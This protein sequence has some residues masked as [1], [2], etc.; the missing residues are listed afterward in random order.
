MKKILFGACALASLLVA[1]VALTSCNNEG[2]TP[3]QPSKEKC[4]KLSFN[5]TIS[6][7]DA[8]T[9]ALGYDSENPKQLNAWWE[10]TEKVYAVNMSAVMSGGSGDVTIDG[11]LQPS[12]NG[13]TT[14]LSGWLTPAEEIHAMEGKTPGDIL[15]FVYPSLAVDYTGQDGTL[16]TIA[17]KYDYAQA[18]TMVTSTENGI[19]EVMDAS[20]MFL[21]GKDPEPDPKPLMAPATRGSLDNTIPFISSQAIVKFTLVDKETG[22]PINATSLTIDAKNIYGESMLMTTSSF[23]HAEYGTVAI[24][25]TSPT[26]NVIYAALSEETE[27]SGTLNYELVAFDGTDAYTYTKSGARFEFGKY[28]E[29]KVK[30]QKMP[31]TGEG[32]KNGYTPVLW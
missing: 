31:K 21:S 23:D 25:R 16:E 3:E 26:D 2:L 13:V 20:S 15:F 1:G 27:Y 5:A 22:N 19:L 9:R 14:T 29:I 28:Y 18:I 8:L 17:Q 30:M 4:Y 10:T 24:N 6:Q 11:Y 7:S 32:E 12:S